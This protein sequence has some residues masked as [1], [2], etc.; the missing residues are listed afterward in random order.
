MV[1]A[2]EAIEHL[3]I[4]DILVSDVF[5]ILKKDGIFIGTVPNAYR[6]KT[7]LDF[8]GGQLRSNK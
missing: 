2:A 3:A 7:K 6:I 4:S 1:V 5:R 8:P